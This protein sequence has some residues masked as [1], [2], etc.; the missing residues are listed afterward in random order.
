MPLFWERVGVIGKMSWIAMLFVLFAVE[1]RAIDKER[2]EA[3]SQFTAIVTGLT[4][5]MEQNQ[6]QFNTTM[7]KTSR[8]LELSKESL[9]HITGGN[10]YCYIAPAPTETR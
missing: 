2:E 1:Y 8:M 4:T 7:E 9:D 10:E 6:P 5:S 3:R